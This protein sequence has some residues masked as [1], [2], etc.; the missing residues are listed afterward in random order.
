MQAL[1]TRGDFASASLHWE[2]WA[3]GALGNIFGYP[4]G[5]HW[6]ERTRHFYLDTYPDVVE[7]GDQLAKQDLRY[8]ETFYEHW[9]ANDA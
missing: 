9:G 2:D 8:C 5:K 1:E 6:W 4:D 3:T 7:L